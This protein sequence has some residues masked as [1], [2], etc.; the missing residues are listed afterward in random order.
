MDDG[1]P[2]LQ[3]LIFSRDRPLQLR[4]CLRT[5]LHQQQRAASA[6]CLRVQTTVVWAASDATFAAGYATVASCIGSRVAF[7][8]ETDLG[9]QLAAM[10]HVPPRTPA[11]HNSL[12]DPACTTPAAAASSQA[13]AMQPPHAAPC[14][15]F[16]FGVDDALWCEQE[17]G[18]AA[19][20]EADPLS[21]AAAVLSRAPWVLAYHAK[22]HPGVCYNHPAG[23]LVRVPTLR[24]L[25]V[26]APTGQG[27]GSAAPSAP[28]ELAQAL[29]FELRVGSHDFSYPGDLCFTVYRTADVKAAV[30]QMMAIHATAS[31]AAAA[32]A[33]GNAADAAA[34]PARSGG[35]GRSSSTRAHSA[36]CSPL[37]H[38]NRFELALNAV[39]SSWVWHPDSQRRGPAAP[40]ATAASG[41]GAP[42]HGTTALPTTAAA[43]GASAPA[44]ATSALWCAIPDAP[45]LVVVTVNRVQDVFANPVYGASVPMSRSVGAAQWDRGSQE[46]DSQKLSAAG[47]AG[48]G[49]GAA[50]SD[51]VRG[52]LTAIEAAGTG[53]DAGMHDDSITQPPEAAAMPPSHLLPDMSP[54]SLLALLHAQPPAALDEGWYGAAQR[55]WNSVHVGAWRLQTA[56]QDSG[57]ASRA[58]LGA[59]CSGYEI[60]VLLPVR[61]GGAALALAL[62][63]T[64]AQAVNWPRLQLVVV[65]DGSVDG[66]A[67]LLRDV[68]AAPHTLCRVLAADAAYGPAG[69]ATAATAV[70]RAWRGGEL[71]VTVARL[72]ES[73]GVARALNHGLLMCTGALIARMDA[74][75]VCEPGR[76]AAQAAYLAARPD[77]D[78]VGAAVEVVVTREKGVED[79]PGAG[80][81]T[82]T[83]RSDDA[84]VDP[85]TL[86]R[87]LVLPCHPA[88]LAWEMWFHAALAHPT[89]MARRGFFM[90]DGRGALAAPALMRPYPTNYAH[91][92]DYGLWLQAL[93]G[94]G[95]CCEGGSRA[96]ERPLSAGA[97]CE[98]CVGTTA[99]DTPRAPVIANIGRV[100]LRLR[101]HSG[102]TNPARV[103][104]QRR[105]A[106]AARL[107]AL[108]A[109][110]M[111][112]RRSL[113]AWAESGALDA[114]A[115]ARVTSWLLPPPDAGMLA[116]AASD[117]CPRA[118][119]PQATDPAASTEGRALLAVTCL[120]EGAAFVVGASLPE[121]SFRAAAAADAGDALLVLEALAEARGC[122]TCAPDAACVDSA[123]S[124][125]PHNLGHCRAE[126]F[127][128]DSEAEV[129]PASA[130]RE[131][132]AADVTA[133]LGELAAAALQ[134]GEAGA[135]GAALWAQWQGRRRVPSGSGVSASVVRSAGPQGSSLAPGV[136]PTARA[137]DPGCSHGGGSDA[138][139]AAGG[140]ASS[141]SAPASAAEPLAR[142]SRA[143]GSRRTLPATLPAHLIAA[144]MGGPVGAA[145]PR[146]SGP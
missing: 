129:V 9:E 86:P 66:T 62:A 120:A 37:S 110:V 135:G 116:L 24:R 124:S 117:N 131:Y 29:L 91:A 74:D 13:P 76:L 43:P 48:S 105:S 104:L 136:A 54:R 40:T 119:A 21:T 82:R 51:Q 19:A 55:A 139:R 25:R 145:Q 127:A 114:G 5:L 121:S 16:A 31:A 113:Q 134:I 146:G 18:Q 80:L 38:P 106:A 98:S 88:V 28:H 87:V 10:L 53:A 49:A 15:Y 65:D 125:A 94:D 115:W 128:A 81:A 63:S 34:A 1:R 118:D 2:S 103:A 20:D 44:H 33:D 126:C 96:P 52:S 50:M 67:E 107:A 3:C 109:A 69:A 32:I 68:V 133:R 92:E 73:V 61:D 111:R 11:A 99:P 6:G 64:L 143:A 140:G 56:C 60:S 70:E 59:A 71:R 84:G 85:R 101:K 4:E 12:A 137:R 46:R 130:V 17:Q 138:S 39:L 72:A 93:W 144:F 83:A 41:T 14:D 7:V 36:I 8:Q 132:V 100:L 112:H 141:C 122:V 102:N 90:A 22:L 89:V 30:M 23:E 45:A 108:R 57:A 77:V 42:E 95:G 35:S 27:R 123:A 47:D 97:I 142:A 78:L 26:P 75:D 58:D 79:A